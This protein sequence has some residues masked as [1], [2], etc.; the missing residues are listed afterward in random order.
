M[1]F[2]HFSQQQANE[3]TSVWLQAQLCKL[4]GM[5]CREK[6]EKTWVWP[7]RRKGILGLTYGEHPGA[8]CWKQLWAERGLLI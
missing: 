1:V 7:M 6:E 3:L 4:C 5:G 8:A 2:Q